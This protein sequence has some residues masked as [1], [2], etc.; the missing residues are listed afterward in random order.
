VYARLN[1]EERH[2]DGSQLAEAVFALLFFITTV[3][4]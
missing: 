2:E 1:A 4:V 3:L